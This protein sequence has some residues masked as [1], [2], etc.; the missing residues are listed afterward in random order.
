[1]IDVTTAASA[2][3]AQVADTPSFALEIE[4]AAIDAVEMRMRQQ[5]PRNLFQRVRDWLRR[6]A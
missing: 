1:M 4:P 3:E 2:D 5:P 6:A